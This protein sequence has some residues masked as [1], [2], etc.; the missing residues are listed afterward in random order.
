MRYDDIELL[1]NEERKILID[2]FVNRDGN[3]NAEDYSN[4]YHFPYKNIKEIEIL[5][6][7]YYINL[8]L[9]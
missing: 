5:G 3:M 1:I 7:K 9:K 2:F 4:K 6:K 8:N